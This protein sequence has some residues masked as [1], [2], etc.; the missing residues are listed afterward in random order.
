MI[1]SN[2]GPKPVS[3]VKRQPKAKA[4]PAAKSTAPQISASQHTVQSSTQDSIRE[5]AFHIYQSHG[6]KP[7]NDMQDWFHAEHQLLAR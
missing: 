3:K 1:V 6:S 4:S 7:G 5:R 2:I